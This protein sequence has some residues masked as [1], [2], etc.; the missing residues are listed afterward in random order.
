MIEQLIREIKARHKSEPISKEDYSAW[1]SSPVTKRLMD[2]LTI[3][4]IEDLC[5]SNIFTAD[6]KSLEVFTVCAVYREGVLDT[7][8]E[9]EE[10]AP[11]ELKGDDNGY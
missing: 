11:I 6:G 5:M 7:T 3:A 1:R 9:V 10:W 4:A 2:D 8:R